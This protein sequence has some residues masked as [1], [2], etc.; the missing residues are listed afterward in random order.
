MLLIFDVDGTI[1]DSWPEI[2]V[3]FKSV[4]SREG[5]PLRMEDLRMSVGLPLNKVIEKLVGRDDEKIVE[6]IRAEFFSLNPRRIRLYDGIKEVLEIP[7]RKAILT[8]KGKAGTYRDLK[9]LGILDRFDMIVDA[10]SVRKVKPDPDGIL[11][12]LSE[13]DAEKNRTFMIGDTE[14]DILAAKNA[15][16]K[17][18]AVTWGNRTREFLEKY[19]PDYIVNSPVELESLLK[20]HAHL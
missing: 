10:D 15:G 17:S 1:I 11:K 19:Q 4:F 9:Y 6:K 3:V 14:M 12:I 7:A 8:S 16:V 5:I 2:E 20:N 18:V 13:M